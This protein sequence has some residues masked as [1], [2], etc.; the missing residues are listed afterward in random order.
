MLWRVFF[1]ASISTFTLS[2]MESLVN[3]APFSL[4]AS[5]TL[6]FGTLEVN[7]DNGFLDI[8]AMIVIGAVCGLL[9]AFFIFVN[10]KMS[11]WRKKN[12]TKNYQKLLEASFFVLATTGVFFLV[13]W[14]RRDSCHKIDLDYEDE[15][16]QFYC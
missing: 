7:E 10:I 1:S 4:S 11:I 13:C 16:V 2:I 14:M 5:A 8:P 15:E 9:G 12:I 6:K 3:G